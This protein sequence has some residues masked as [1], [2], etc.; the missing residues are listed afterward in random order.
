MYNYLNN[1]INTIKNKTD[2]KALE[3]IKLNHK[4]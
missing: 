1:W 3:V 2:R 4:L